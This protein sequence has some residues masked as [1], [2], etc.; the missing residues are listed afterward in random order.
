MLKFGMMGLIPLTIRDMGFLLPKCDLGEPD[1][2]WGS[3]VVWLKEGKLEL[4]LGAVRYL[5]RRRCARMLPV[6]C[7]APRYLDTPADLTCL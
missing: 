6:W 7:V 5:T 1:G 2:A 3:E 4:R